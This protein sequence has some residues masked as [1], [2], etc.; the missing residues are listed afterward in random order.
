VKTTWFI[1][2]AS[3]QLPTEP[4][5]QAYGDGAARAVAAIG[6]SDI[7]A[8]YRTARSRSCE[9]DHTSEERRLQLAEHREMRGIEPLL[10]IA[11]G[12]PK[13]VVEQREGWFRET[14][15]ARVG[16]RPTQRAT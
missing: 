14:A 13:V 2:L 9:R 11:L 1:E 6:A 15:D 12:D 7:Y 5:N 10:P 4:R 8:R 3:A 16:R